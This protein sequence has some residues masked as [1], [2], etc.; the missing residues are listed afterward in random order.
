MEKRVR[1]LVTKL[2]LDGHDR[3]AKLVARALRDA[4]ME[5]IYLKF[6]TPADVMRTVIDEDVDAVGVSILSGGHLTLLPRL[7][8]LLREN[9]L[10]HVAVIAGGTIPREDY[11]ALRRAGVATVCAR[12]VTAAEIV[13]CVRRCVAERDAA[14]A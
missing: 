4:G 3:G 11:P 13:D 12:E 7:C 8:A 14:R 6:Q 2:G 1:V 5:V 9:E 10:E